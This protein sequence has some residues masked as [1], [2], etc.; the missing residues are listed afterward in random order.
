MEIPTHTMEGEKIRESIVIVK[1]R[2]LGSSH[3]GAAEMNLTNNH[4]VAGSIPGL[5]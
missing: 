1:K 3:G 2:N 5:T 4:E